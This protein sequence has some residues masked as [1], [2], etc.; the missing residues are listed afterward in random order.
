M[1]QADHERIRRIH[2]AFCAGD[3]EALLAAVEDRDAVPNGPMPL[4]IGSCLEYAIYHSP[5]PFIRTL[6]ELGA[7]PN[8]DDPAG[9]PSLIAALSCSQ[10]HPGSPARADVDEIVRLL[11][12]SGVNPNQRGI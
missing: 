7:D 4:A 12:S 1:R 9:F 2:A 10:P 6:L 3:L 8:R 5:L 11:L